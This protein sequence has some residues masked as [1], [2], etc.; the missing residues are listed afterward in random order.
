M[1]RLGGYVL[2][3]LIVLVLQGCSEQQAQYNA[4]LRFYYDGEV[5]EAYRRM[6]P[7]AQAGMPDAQFHVGLEVL[8]ASVSG[9]ADAQ[10]GYLWMRL[11]AEKGHLGARYLLAD[12]A[13]KGVRMAGNPAYAL[14]EFGR[15]AEEGLVPAQWRMVVM[16]EADPGRWP[17]LRRWLQAAAEQGHKAAQTRLIQAYAAGELGFPVDAARATY[18]RDRQK[19]GAFR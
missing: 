5:Q 7:L 19:G 8:K 9:R 13:A 16:L 1:T 2:A 10:Q 4:A 3:G 11:A 14:E 12:Q 15:L 18:W 6:L 17:E